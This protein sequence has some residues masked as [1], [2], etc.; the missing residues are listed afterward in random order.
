M[1]QLYV[2]AP[3]AVNTA[4]L[5]VQIVGLLTVIVGFEFTERF[6]VV[7]PVQIPL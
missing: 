5:P 7:E 1:F 2:V 4:E 3:F 6:T